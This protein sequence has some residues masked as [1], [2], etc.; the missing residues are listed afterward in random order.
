VAA[1]HRLACRWGEQ[2]APIFTSG[3]I[4][5]EVGGYLEATPHGGL[6]ASTAW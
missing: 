2:P 3:K 5:Y 4:T 1:R 6:A